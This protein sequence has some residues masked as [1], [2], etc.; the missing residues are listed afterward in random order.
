MTDTTNERSAVL[1]CPKCGDA[2]ELGTIERLHGV[3]GCSQIT[4][5]DGPDWAGRTDLD[6][7]SSKTVGVACRC[8]WEYLGDDWKARLVPA[9]VEA[10]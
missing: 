7:D 9:L 3:A 10:D 6:W 1:A 8:G 2:E 4:A 5:E